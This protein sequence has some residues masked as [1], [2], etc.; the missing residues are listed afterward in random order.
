MFLKN[1]QTCIVNLFFYVVMQTY[2]CEVKIQILDF[3]KV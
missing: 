1:A 3:G 2:V